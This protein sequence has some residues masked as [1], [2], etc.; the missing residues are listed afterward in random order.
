MSMFCR[1]DKVV[2]SDDCRCKVGFKQWP[3]EWR[4]SVEVVW[5]RCRI[6]K[7]HSTNCWCKHRVETRN[8][9]GFFEGPHEEKKGGKNE[10]I[11]EQRIRVEE[12]KAQKDNRFLRR[13]QIANFIYENTERGA[14]TKGAKFLHRAED[15][16]MFSAED[17]WVL[18]KEETLVVFFTR[19][20]RETV[21][22]RGKKWETQENL[23]WSK[24]PLQFRKWRN[25]LTWKAQTVWR[26]VLR[27]EL[28]K[29]LTIAGQDEKDRR[30]II[31]IIPVCRGY[32]SRNRC[33]P[34]LCISTLR[35]NEFYSTESWRNGIERFGGSHLKFS[36]RTW[37]ETKIRERTIWKHYPKRRTSWEKSLRVQFGGT[38]TWGNLT[39]S[40]LY[41]QSSMEFS[42]KICKLK[43]EDKATFF[44]LWRRQRHRRSHVCCG[45]GS[46]NAQCWARESRAQV[47]WIHWKVQ[48]P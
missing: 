7:R 31:D 23:A 18:F 5:N 29:P 6:V 40:K 17:N 13:R 9:Q 27:L 42:E 30:V 8:R 14:V 48:T 3:S 26:P 45:F 28:K 20:P 15:W 4:N 10:K 38:N 47:Q 37:Y 22:Q 33:I 44:L 41:Q 2:L 32:V 35:S 19:I 43:A 39:T 24:H 21:R 36:G 34:K 16:R 1:I 11:D 12:Q 46:F 25:R